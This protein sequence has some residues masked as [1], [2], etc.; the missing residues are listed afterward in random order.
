MII[1]VGAGPAGS[2]LSYL[3]AKQ[4]KKVLLLE[5]HDSIGVPVQCTGLVTDSILDIMPL[6]KDLIVNKI[7]KTRVYS[8]KDVFADIDLKPH[9]VLD[10]TKFDQ[11]L[12]KLAVK[13][14]V[15]AH[16]SEKF[17]SFRRIHNSVLVKSSKAKDELLA[18]FLVGCDGPV[19]EVGK[20]ANLIKNREFFIGM[21]YRMS[22]DFDSDLM[23]LWLFDKGFGWVVPESS[24][25]ARVGVVSAKNPKQSLNRFLSER[26]SKDNKILDKK[27]GIIPFFDPKAGRSYTNVLLCGDAGGFVKNSSG[28]GIIP[29]LISA[30]CACKA[31][32]KKKSYE[33]LWKKHLNKNLITHFLIRKVLNRMGQK[34]RDE[35]VNIFRQKR[36][37]KLLKKI[38]R[39]HAFPLTIKCFLSNPRL[40]KFAKFLF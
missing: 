20:S 33:K 18:N 15:E 38:D 32:T 17:T 26:F 37:K 21:E 39:D 16:L 25:M 8:S 4:G 31:I 3:L 22:G 1:V 11:H 10:R 28:G 40:L 6:K 7:N 35:L 23:E 9:F 2:Y 27:A 14:G 34:D 36:M 24:D 29:G 19:S 12:F 13:E 5:E 30:E